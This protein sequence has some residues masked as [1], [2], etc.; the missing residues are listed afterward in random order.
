MNKK[1]L[2]IASILKPLKDPRHYERFAL[3]LAKTNK[4]GINIIANGEKKPDE[5][6]IRFFSNGIHRRSLFNRLKLQW[7]TCQ[8]IVKIQPQFLIICTIELLPFA[9]LYT[10]LRPCK[11]I[12]DVQENYDLNFKHLKEY[13][14]VHRHLF[15]RLV[16]WLEGISS[17]AVHH[18]FL[19]EKCYSNQL[20]FIQEKY[21]ILENKVVLIDPTKKRKPIQKEQWKFL[22]SG[23]LSAYAGIYRVI[24]LTKVLSQSN[25][26]FEITIIGQYFDP[27]IGTLLKEIDQENI[28]LIIDQRPIPH[29]QIIDEIKKAD[30]GII[31]YESN[32]VNKD[33]VPSKLYEYTA[34]G[35]PYLVEKDSTWAQ[36]GNQL[37]G[38]IPIRF[39]QFSAEYIHKIINQSENH[40]GNKIIESVLWS[41]EETKLINSLKNL[42]NQVYL[43]D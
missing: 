28:H 35:L 1:I 16:R 21:T 14:F 9:I 31:A 4:Y 8:R 26:N 29:D 2:A 43:I 41:G 5:T 23:T 24:E 12:Y 15:R 3:S 13:G 6:N 37:G 10:R 38:A 30:L 25:I 11:L 22:F 33:K 18:Y 36:L 32:P 20:S 34:F 42:S 39:D 19:A 40:N 27:A 17:S 7:N